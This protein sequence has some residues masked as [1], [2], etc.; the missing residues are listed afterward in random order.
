MPSD[1]I[2]EKT[3]M[4]I[5]DYDAV[6]KAYDAGNRDWDVSQN[7]EALMA[8]LRSTFPETTLRIL[9]CGCAGGRDVATFESMGCDVLGIDGSPALLDI[10]K[11]RRLK[12]TLECQDFTALQLD[13][14]AFHGIFANAVLQHVPSECIDDVLKTF[15]RSLKKDGVFFSSTAHGFGQDSE[16]LAPGRTSKTR[17]WCCF[18]SDA[19]WRKKCHDAGFTL[20]DAYFRGHTNGFYA[21]AWR[22]S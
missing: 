17:S 9:D 8:P 6:A 22:K 12:A 15:H 4:T 13:D 10:A 2:L 18:W 19:T 14:E 11:E 16:Y 7:V 21:S 20:L 1:G 5:A 3:R